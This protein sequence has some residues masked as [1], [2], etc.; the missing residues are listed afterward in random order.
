MKIEMVLKRLPIDVEDELVY[1]FVKIDSGFN[2]TD[3]IRKGGWEY[4]C[5]V[6]E[7]N[8]CAVIVLLVEGYVYGLA[9]GEVLSD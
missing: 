2:P 8:A 1:F 7:G 9:L 6:A 3:I 5:D 4:A